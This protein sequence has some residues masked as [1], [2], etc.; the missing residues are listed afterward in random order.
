MCFKNLTRFFLETSKYRYIVGVIYS[1]DYTGETASKIGGTIKQPMLADNPFQ[2]PSIYFGHDP[3][4]LRRN[5]EICPTGR[6]SNWEPHRHRLSLPW[7]NRA[8]DHLT[9]LVIPRQRWPDCLLRWNPQQMLP[10]NLIQSTLKSWN[11]NS[12]IFWKENNSIVIR[13]ATIDALRRV[14][15]HRP[16]TTD[17]L[18]FLFTGTP[19][20]T[21][22]CVLLLT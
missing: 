14:S 7:Q 10:G 18:S 19:N 17:L 1:F 22:N 11:L 16:R 21:L 8:K 12:N 15:C 5:G 20:R 4:L 3:R 9:G 13:L 2:S 6:L